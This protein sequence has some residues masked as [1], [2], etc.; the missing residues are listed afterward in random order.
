MCYFMKMVNITV[1][2]FLLIDRQVNCATFSIKHD[3]RNIWNMDLETLFGRIL[4]KMF[5]ETC[6][7][8]VITMFME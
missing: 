5:D 4:Q 3:F 7:I 2:S 8:A 1:K 6:L